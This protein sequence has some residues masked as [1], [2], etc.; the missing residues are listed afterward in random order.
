MS[1]PSDLSRMSRLSMVLT[2]SDAPL[3]R[4]RSSG[5]MGVVLLSRDAMKDA[6]L[7]RM[8][9]IPLEV[10]YAPVPLEADRI[11]FARVTTSDGNDL[12]SSGWDS[13]CGD[14]HRETS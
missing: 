4:N 11:D 13:K 1:T 7:A 10:E 6:T 8:D 14:A 5:S 12:S 2:P 3:V 9:G